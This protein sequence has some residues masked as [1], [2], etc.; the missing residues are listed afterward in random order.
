MT[1]RVDL[2]TGIQAAY[3]NLWRKNDN[4]FYVITDTH[5]I[6]LGY[7]LIFSEDRFKYVVIGENN[8]IDIVT[9]GIRGSITVSFSDYN[10][11]SEL[12]EA[13]EDA[14][15]QA[16]KI[17]GYI[18]SSEI[19]PKF[20]TSEEEGNVYV[21]SDEFSIGNKPGQISSNLFVDGVS[22]NSYPPGTDIVIVNAGTESNPIYKFN[23]LSDSIDLDNYKV[24]Q[25][26]KSDPQVS[27]ET[28]SVID[29][30][31]QNINGEI[32]ATKKTIQLAS[33]S[34]SGIIT[35]EMYTKIDDF[36][37]EDPDPITFE[38]IDQIFDN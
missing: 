21:V 5:N 27:G 29:S 19:G 23:V 36:E 13:I 25:A 7:T 33:S 28:L 20:L 30:I 22:G 15:S 10:T 11:N 9:Y 38:E 2:A 32:T 17:V 34:Q 6:Y 37:Y 8:S 18:T 4:T 14:V 1:T 3:N 24:K 26:P 35:K 31:T 16:Y 12:L